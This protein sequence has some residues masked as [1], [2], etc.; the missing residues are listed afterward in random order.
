MNIQE[1]GGFDWGRFVG[2]IFESVSAERQ[3]DRVQELELAK[4]NA[5]KTAADSAKTYTEGQSTVAVSGM[6]YLP[7]ILGGAALLV[8]IFMLTRG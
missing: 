5:L 2:G 3:A 6:Q 8:G 7:V 4:I 1:T